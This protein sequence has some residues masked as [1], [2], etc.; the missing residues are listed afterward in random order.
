MKT[1]DTL[2]TGGTEQGGQTP[3]GQLCNGYVNAYITLVW[4]PNYWADW[5]PDH[6]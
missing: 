3:K 2:V 4:L 5:K 6:Y 1:F